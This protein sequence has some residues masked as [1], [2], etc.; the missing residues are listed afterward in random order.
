MLH[1][2]NNRKRGV[3]S[4]AEGVA[5]RMRKLR[6]LVVRLAGWRGRAGQE[7]ELHEEPRA[8]WTANLLED[9][10]Q[11]L[12][13]ALRGL[14]RNPAFALTAILSLAIGIGASIAIFTVA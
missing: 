11:D 6:A 13:Y 4:A 12:V 14:G 3:T 5:D 7:R 2:E 1:S 10:R 8:G 9:T